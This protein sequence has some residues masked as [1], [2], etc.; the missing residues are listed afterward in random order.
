MK[1][2]LFIAILVSISSI[3]FSQKVKIDKIE[4]KIENGEAWV[5]GSDKD[6]EV[7]NILS[8]VEYQGKSYPVTRISV[9]SKNALSGFAFAK[10]K[11][12]SSVSIPNSVTSISH[13]AFW[14]CK[15]LEKVSIPNTVKFIG[16]AAFGETPIRKLIVPD[17]PMEICRNGEEWP[18]ARFNPFYECKNLTEI[19]CHNGSFPTYMLRHLPEDCTFMLAQKYQQGGQDN[20][21]YPKNVQQP[22][23]PNS[24]TIIQQDRK[25]SSDVDVNLPSNAVTNDK[26]FAVIFA[27][28]NYQEEV[29]VEYAEN[30]GEMFKEY[31]NKVLG[32]P[33]D[34]IHLRKNATKN[35]MIAE[36]SWMKKVA[37]AYDG[38]AKF[39][40]FYAG[41]G[42]PDEKTGSAYL[43]PVDGIGTEP[44]TAYSLAQFYKTL[45]A[46]PAAN[47]TVFMDACFSGSKRGEGM[48]ASSRGVAIKAKTQAP[49]GKMVVFSAAQGDET[50]YPFKEKGHGLFTYYLLKKLQETKGNV[51]YGELSTYLQTEVKRK[52]IVANNK[53]QTPTV[54]A[55]Q[56]VANNWKTMKLK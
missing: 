8:S 56:S 55:S 46:L 15:S 51:T 2:L 43:L 36:I 24:N 30:D 31:C 40:V 37:D 12:L 25:P 50:A 38:Q 33:E 19:K 41:H 32:I 52:S 45:G 27:N 11:K 5:C 6:I 23:I 28:E 20:N 3:S 10:R 13:Y 22:V 18:Q 53:S 7:A 35:N 14:L 54:N 4:Y 9:E 26:T 39:I 16:L 17:S 1:R 34:N 47:I 42:I 44:E 49:Q 29:K 21:M 48:L